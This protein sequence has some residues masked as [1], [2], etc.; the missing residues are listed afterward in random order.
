M[1]LRVVSACALV[2]LVALSVPAFGAVDMDRRRASRNESALPAGWKPA[3]LSQQRDGRFFVQLKAPA[4]LERGRLG[5]AAQ[6]AASATVLRSQAGAIREAE[7]AGGAVIF[8]YSKLVNAFS[9]QISAE[10]AASLAQRSDVA[11][12]ERVPIVVRHNE[13]SVPFIGA[14]KVHKK[15]GV[16]GKGVTVAV[17]DTGVDYNHANFGGS[18]DPADY[19]ANDPDVIEPGSFPT[20]KVIAGFDFVGGNYSVIDDDS[21]NDVPNPDP[22]PLDDAIVG[23]HGTHVA[24]TCC[25]IGVPGIIGRGVAPK[26]K[27]VAVKVWDDGNSTADVLVAGY[28]FAMDPDQDGSTD[29][30]VDVISFSGGVDYGPSSSVEAQAAQAVVDGGTVFV[31]S[32]GNS[33]HQAVGGNGYILG[34][35]A[36]AKGVI[37]VAASIDQFVA[38]QLVVNSPADVA[39]PDGGPIVSQ[40]WAVQFDS[41]LTGDVVDAREF[42]PPADPSGEPVPTDRILCDDTPPGQP[43]AG[44]F[45]LIFKGPFGGGDCFVEDKV[46]HAQ[47]AGAIG[48]II[49]DGFGGLPGQIS[50]GGNEGQVTIPAVD[51][52]GNDS[53]AMAAAMSPNAPGSYNE[54]T[55]NVTLG[56]SGSIIPG[57]E[58]RMVDFS[59]EGPSRYRSGLKPDVAAPGADITSSNA[60]TGTESLTISGTSMAAPHV[61]GVAALLTQIHPSF[62]P[63][64]I[65]ALIMN[66]ATQD[67]TELDGSTVSATV[68]GS[69]RVQADE[70]ALADSLAVPGSLSYGRR[71]VSDVFTSV[72]SFTLHNLSNHKQK[73]RAEASV[74]FHDN[75]ATKFASVRIA[76]GDEQLAPSHTFSVKAGEKVKI[77]VEL[78]LDPSRVPKWQ[79]ELGWFFFNGNVDGSVDIV[80]KGKKGDELHVPWHVTPLAAGDSRVFPA[81]L[82]LTA[83]SADLALLDKG[84]GVHYADLYVLGDED[85]VDDGA[86]GDVVAIGARSFVGVSVDGVPEGVPPGAD[87]LAG[88]D[89][90]SFLTS[91]D[92]PAEPIEFAV[93]GA[94]PHNITETTEIDVLIDV[95]ADGVFADSGLDADVLVVKLAEGGTG[96]VCVFVLPSDFSACD[97]IYFQDYSNYNASVWGI[98]VDVGVLGLTTGSPLISYRV[99]ACTGVYAGDLPDD[100]VCDT[101]GGI[102]QTTGTYLAKLDVIHPA[103]TFSNQVIGGFWGGPQGSVSVGV[104]QDPGDDPGI[105]AVFPNNAPDDQYAVVTTTT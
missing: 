77:F 20:N 50:P 46:I 43:F 53:A 86:E 103:L 2:M 73:Y 16:E 7:A 105:L 27:I 66:Q 21:S 99:V 32:A 69:G 94:D 81:A 14:T 84:D 82:D 35:P 95:G 18:G 45:A 68:F 11:L 88:I 3:V 58:D 70:S 72:R 92:T 90:L 41:D 65:K 93:V 51:L 52:S 28:E 40:D 17:V 19:A 57:Y 56:A 24:G 49:W 15:L 34:T 64:K 104:G 26:S 37:A 102:D 54:V 48:V 33:G 44:K 55:G 42:D 62:S 59:S 79:Q 5:V 13:T 100:R 36:S 10:G 47:Q 98:P 83:G 101:A 96:Q 29:D 67:V 39:L 74:R 63:A 25:G 89:W 78:R 8:R 12:V 38:Q 6:R 23:D 31:A 80:E 75:L 85:P 9:V 71:G 87:A 91:V 60:G 4:V 97:A 1:R 30:A 76:I 61:S 22:D